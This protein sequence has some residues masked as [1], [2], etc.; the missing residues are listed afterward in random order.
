MILHTC[1]HMSIFHMNFAIAVDHIL[2]IIKGIKRLVLLQCAK[3][4]AKIQCL[5]IRRQCV[6]FYFI[7]IIY[8]V[9]S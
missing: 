2:L 3:G 5:Q 7:L 9:N 1:V 6:S 4:E 8:F